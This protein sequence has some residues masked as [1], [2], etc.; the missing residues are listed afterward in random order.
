MVQKVDS[1]REQASS[2]RFS[3]LWGKA[4]L[5]LTVGL[6]IAGPAHALSGGAGSAALEEGSPWEG[7]G[8]LSVNGQLFTATLIAP[9]YVL[10]AAHVVSGADAS[11]VV[12]QTTTGESFSSVASAIYVDPTYT[13]G[14][15]GNVA[16]DPT[17]HGDL[18]IVRLSDATQDLSTYSLYAGDLYK[19]TISMVSFGGSSTQATTGANRVD[20]LFADGSGTDQT[21]AFDRDGS[22]LSS[23]MIGN[24]IPANGTL[25]E[26]VEAGIV[27][28]DSGSAAFV[29]ANGQWQLA[30]INTFS[31][32]FA[33]GSTT[34]GDVGTGGGGIVLASQMDWIQSVITAPVPE[35]ESAWMLLA[36]LAVLGSGQWRRG[37]RARA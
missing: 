4:A 14:T 9:G 30:G 36:G 16:G 28:G 32:L 12:F 26:G 35:P 5:A 11:S 29:Y 31:L 37:R 7:V 27:H 19:Q 22:Q 21:Y 18:A 34:Q 6:A 1:R 25:G 20:L 3:P 23:N 33:G 24:D 8:S 10:T 17:V 13:G 2:S 15:A